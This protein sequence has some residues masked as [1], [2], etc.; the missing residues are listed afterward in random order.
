MDETFFLL[1]I[2]LLAALRFL[3][4]KISYGREKPGIQNLSRRES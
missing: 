1:I 3:F 2:L 4:I